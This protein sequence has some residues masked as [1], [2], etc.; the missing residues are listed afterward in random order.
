[1][2]YEEKII[3]DY[4]NSIKVD[5]PVFKN[6]HAESEK[7]SLKDFF[8][9]SFALVFIVIIFINSFSLK[10]IRCTVRKSVRIYTNNDILLPR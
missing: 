3:K 9:D 5:V 2:N 4:Y 7:I 6:I 8:S 1:M 10:K